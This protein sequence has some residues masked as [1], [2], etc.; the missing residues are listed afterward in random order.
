M[1]ELISSGSAISALNYG[2]RWAKKIHNGLVVPSCERQ[3][4]TQGKDGC[5]STHIQQQQLQHSTYMMKMVLN[6]FIQLVQTVM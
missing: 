6:S 3:Q 1:S 2:S 4:S 5:T